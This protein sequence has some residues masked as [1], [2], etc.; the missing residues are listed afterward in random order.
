MENGNL[1]PGI[2]DYTMKEFEEQFVLGFESSQSRQTIFEEFSIWLRDLVSLIPPRHLWLDGSYLTKK[3]NPNDI[4]LVVFYR[5]E[6]INAETAQ[7]VQKMVN[8]VSRAHRCDAY[9]CYDLSQM[10]P[11]HVAQFPQQAQMME[12][13]W[14]G[15]FGFDRKRDPKGMVQIGSE[16]ILKFG[17]VYNGVSSRAN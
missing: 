6:D 2:H 5:P 3:E 10:H 12:K 14:M 7:Q 13:Y 15:Q 8:E 17:G 16:E 1:F 9:I 4:D 11:A